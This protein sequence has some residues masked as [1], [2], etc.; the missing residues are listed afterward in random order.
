MELEDTNEEEN[1]GQ[2]EEKNPVIIT[3]AKNWNKIPNE[4]L[5]PDQET[6][7][8]SKFTN[9]ILQNRLP[10]STSE[11]LVKFVQ[12]IAETCEENLLSQYTCS[13]K[14]VTKEA[15]KISASLK[16][17]LFKQLKN[18][19]FSLSIDESSNF[20][21]QSYLLFSRKPRPRPFMKLATEV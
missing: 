8:D 3:K 17:D 1:K 21:G 10:F 7:L 9:F 12:E 15:R 18:S 20:Y 2:I 14:K 11:S 16:S 6:C 13:R 4:K 19:P 5:S